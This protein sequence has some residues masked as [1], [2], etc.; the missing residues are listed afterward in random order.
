MDLTIN[1]KITYALPDDSPSTSTAILADGTQSQIMV[2]PK[3]AASLISDIQLKVGNNAVY[4]VP[5][6]RIHQM[7][8]A[9]SLPKDFVESSTQYFDHNSA[10]A[11]DVQGWVFNLKP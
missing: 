7:I 8:I 11:G 4:T 2:V 9:Q 1:Y 10:N 3:T 6:N 5:F